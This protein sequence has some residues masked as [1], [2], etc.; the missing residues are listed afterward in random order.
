[1]A[2]YASVD[3]SMSLDQTMSR[4]RTIYAP[5]GSWQ[6]LVS[7]IRSLDVRKV[8]LRITSMEDRSRA[9]TMPRRLSVRSEPGKRAWLS[10]IAVM[11]MERTT[12][13]A[14][15]NAISWRVPTASLRCCPRM[16][17][18]RESRPSTAAAEGEFDARL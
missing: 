9:Q 4:G 6:P 3:F 18:M 15:E 17:K 2:P 16:S 11:A 10:T 13:E 14:T 7:I 5:P 8:R 12:K 1:M